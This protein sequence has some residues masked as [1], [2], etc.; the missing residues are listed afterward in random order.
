ME[1]L[2]VLYSSNTIHIGNVVL[3]RYLPLLL[4]PQRLASVTSLELVWSLVLFR[5]LP[6]P[7]TEQEIGWPA[8]NALGLVLASAFPRLRKLYVSIQTGSYNLNPLHGDIAHSEQKLLG[9]IDEMVRKFSSQ[10]QQCVISPN[11]S[12]YTALMCRAESMGACMEG[13]GQGCLRWHRFWR[14]VAVEQGAQSGN[15]QGYW[16]GQG[17]DDTPPSC[18]FGEG[19][20]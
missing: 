1:S 19:F 11:L 8:Y 17:E 12:L 20:S 9:P 6:D 3:T 2:D 16:V 4:L 15:N 14:P 18:T 13:G 5:S 7:Q 10:L